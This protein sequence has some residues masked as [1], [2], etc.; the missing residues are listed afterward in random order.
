L[1][2]VR[3]TGP[4][5]GHN[6]SFS[7]KG[8]KERRGAG[9]GEKKRE[10]RRGEGGGEEGGREGKEGREKEREKGGEGK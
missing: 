5:L 4:G 6:P 8:G 3:R 1:P 10:G 2:R 7:R 9:E